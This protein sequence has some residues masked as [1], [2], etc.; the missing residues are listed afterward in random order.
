MDTLAH[1]LWAGLGLV[2]ARRHV[3]IAP[4][5]ALAAVGL[6]VL[7]DLAHLLPL[8]AGGGG[9]RT[10]ADYIGATPG[11]E[12]ALAP[13]VAML[14][15][16]LHCIGHS[17]VIAGAVTLAAWRWRRAWMIPLAGWWSHIVI[18]VFTHSADFYPSPVLYPLTMRGFHGVAWNEPWFMALNYVAL[19]AC[20]IWLVASRR[21][22]RQP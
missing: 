7:P 3:P 19:G 1:A 14:S 21:R 5:V 11:A 12:P 13:R 18:D 15:H 17:A 22:N 16:H 8:L 4:R 2:A 20:A 6:A 9:W 10:L